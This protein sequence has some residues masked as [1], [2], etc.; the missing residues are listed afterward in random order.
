MVQFHSL[1]DLRHFPGKSFINPFVFQARH[2]AI[3]AKLETPFKFDSS[4]FVVQYDVKFE[5]G[6][7]CGGGYLKL[8][9][10]GAEKDLANFQDKT[11]Y[12]IM[13]G[14]DKCGASGQV[15][16]IFRYRNPVNGTVAEYHAKQP[17]SIPTTYWDDHNTHLFTLVV[18]PTGDFAVSV[19]GK[20][21]FYG[22]MLS[23]GDM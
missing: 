4:N 10:E 13:F 19:D 7:E 17:S 11:S 12:T 8:L 2:H 14:P 22:N 3:A 1:L 23:V 21:L 16:L 20:S 9:S 6:Q 15:H 5:E 18:K